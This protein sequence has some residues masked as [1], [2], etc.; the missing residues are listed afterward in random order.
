MYES[1]YG[2]KEKPFSIQPD[3]DYLF[4]SQ[5]HTLAYSMLEY[6]LLNRAGFTVICGDIGCGKTT[7]IRHL[8]NALGDDLVV[9]LITNSHQGMGDMLEWVMLAYGLPFEGK[10]QAAL[11]DAF[12]RF[13]IAEYGKG[14]RA[15]LIVDEAQNLSVS[16]LESLRMLSN[17]N[18]DKDQLLQMIL[19]GQPQL[20]DL[21]KRPELVQV[22]QRVAVDFF[23]PPLKPEEV[24]DYIELRLRVAG[25]EGQLFSPAAMNRV[26]QLTH[27]IPRKINTLCDLA[28]VYA[29]THEAKLVDVEIIDEVQRDR[30]EF[31]IL[32]DSSGHPGHALS[33]AN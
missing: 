18:A 5:R 21:L 33:G 26:A 12:Q 29:Y 11:Y 9:G 1:F 3:P 14:R 31:G 27:G 25:R 30:H 32:G 6:G 19:V 16:A 17:I 20:R 4:M 10:S 8:L 28:L 23:I 22:A 13:L 24:A 7:L 15:V 2:L